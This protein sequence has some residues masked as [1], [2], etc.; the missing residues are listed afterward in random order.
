MK[1]V[2]ITSF[3]DP[4]VLQIREVEAPKSSQREILVGVRATALNRADVLQRRG[5][6]PRLRQEAETIFRGW[7][8]PEGWRPL[9]GTLQDGRLAIRSWA[10]C[11][12][13]D[14]P[15]KS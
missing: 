7:N 12:A 5:E 8:S 1:A 9:A 6:Y 3:G 15:R 2:V 14:T 10:F 13:R 4:E 11:L